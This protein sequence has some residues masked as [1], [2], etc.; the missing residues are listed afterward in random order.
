MHRQLNSSCLSCSICFFATNVSQF[1]NLLAIFCSPFLEESIPQFRFSTQAYF[2]LFEPELPIDSP[3][4]AVIVGIQTPG[5]SHEEPYPTFFSSQCLT[6]TSASASEEIPLL[7]AY[8]SQDQK[9][10]GN[11]AEELERY[12]H[13]KK[14]KALVAKPTALNPELVF[15]IT[16]MSDRHPEE[17]G[18]VARWAYHCSSERTQLHLEPYQRDVTNVKRSGEWLNMES[19]NLVPGDFVKHDRDIQEH[20]G[21]GMNSDRSCRSARSC[22]SLCTVTQ[23][24][25]VVSL[26]SF[27][28]VHFNEVCV[29]EG[30]VIVSPLCLFSVFV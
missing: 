13:L 22:F 10:Y 28:Q 27:S 23:L 2:Y 11:D 7:Y 30:V 15:G 19:R 12:G 6:S 9:H 21:E 26:V 16:S 24:N 4:V 29:A 5:W 20:D 1:F 25:V 17:S 14:S 3:F 18:N 8:C